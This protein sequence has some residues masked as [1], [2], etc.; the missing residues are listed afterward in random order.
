MPAS[1]LVGISVGG[2]A[3]IGAGALTWGAIGAGA[4]AAGLNLLGRALI[5]EPERQRQD[6]STPV[7]AAVTQCRWII[8]TVRTGGRLIY[9]ERDEKYNDTLHAI[10]V[11]SEGPI[12][13]SSG[14]ADLGIQGIY[15]AGTSATRINAYVHP[16]YPGDSQAHIPPIRVWVPRQ[17]NGANA[18]R[19]FGNVEIVL[20]GAADGA[21]QQFLIDTIPG[22]TDKDTVDG[23]SYMYVKLVNAENGMRGRGGTGFIKPNIPLNRPGT[24]PALSRAYQAFNDYSGVPSGRTPEER[25]ERFNTQRS[26]NT[27]LLYTSPSPRD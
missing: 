11:L 14:G 7:R 9:V 24:P 12:E 20:F 18:N 25:I 27:C 21:K 19:L 1:V 4:F 15:I 8:G 22:W 2:G 10:Y 6:R 16:D 26:P 13:Y 17:G 23:K 3:A 5:R